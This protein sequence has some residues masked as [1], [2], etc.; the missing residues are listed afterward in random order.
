MSR[1]SRFTRRHKHQSKIVKIDGHTFQSQIEAD[2]YGELKWLEREGRISDI[3]VHPRFK[4]EYNGVKICTVVLDFSY[5]LVRRGCCTACQEYKCDDCIGDGYYC[6]CDHVPA[7]YEDVKAQTFGRDGKVSYTT[8][9]RISK[10][11]RNLL[12]AFKNIDV[13]I[14]FP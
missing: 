7:I 4:I 14:F 10:I 6:A 1:Y 12:K 13:E 11:G 9:T 8:D 5:R 2:R 3:K